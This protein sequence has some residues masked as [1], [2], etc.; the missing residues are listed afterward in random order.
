MRVAPDSDFPAL[1]L[2]FISAVVLS[3]LTFFL[4]AQKE[5]KSILVD[6]L[7]SSRF[8][9]VPINKYISFPQRE[10][11]AYSSIIQNTLR[12]IKLLIS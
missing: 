9:E 6:F 3:L 4:P 2:S 12:L 8:L 1:L 5:S 11:K 10:V 7:L